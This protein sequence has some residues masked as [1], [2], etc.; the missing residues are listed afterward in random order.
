MLNNIKIYSIDTE[1]NKTNLIEIETIILN[2]LYRFSILGIN[3]KNS[4]DTKDRIYSALRSQRLVNLKS[5]NKKITV[6][7]LPTN[8][9]KKTNIYD[10]SIALSYL[11]C[12]DQINIDE[13]AIVIG[14][15]SILGNIIPGN[16]IIR[17]IYQAIKNNIKIIVCTQVEID[18]LDKNKIDIQKLII[19]NNI[20]FISSNNLGD[21]INN[22]KNK[23]YS[24]LKGKENESIDKGICKITPDTNLIKIKSSKDLN[25]NILKIILAICTKRNIF[26]ENTKK[27]F[28]KKYIE[29]LIYYN[30]KLNPIEVLK[31]SNMLNLSDDQILETYTYPK[32]SILDSQTQKNDLSDLLNKSLFGFNIIEDFLN[33]SEES[34]YIIKK[35][36][37]SSILCFYNSCPCGNSNVFFNN[38]GNNKCF[39]LQR[40][41]LKYRQRIQRIENGFFDF[42]INTAYENSIDYI[43]DD[44][45]KVN[46]I[47]SKFRNAEV[48]IIDEYASN[49]FIEKNINLLDRA[50]LDKILC[51]ARDIAKLNHIL[52]EEEPKLNQENID[53][54][55]QLLKKDF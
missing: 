10:L 50:Y 25:I 36:N 55:I 6:N 23:S 52:T 34:L 41:I 5:D 33:M 51:L 1:L 46:N 15:L 26:I 28:I 32:V 21:L 12:M 48:K 3:Q 44:Y 16:F 9:V 29:N 54:A 45:I 42:H 53:L 13:D 22:I 49:I 35:Y 20:K 24:V 40:N 14:E 19:E 17:S 4:T 47:I 18:R 39:C 2:G 37:S 31:M 43:S 7:L 38:I 27:S 8:I 11:S 30:K